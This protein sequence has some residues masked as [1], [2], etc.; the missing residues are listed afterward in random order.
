V[1]TPQASIPWSS[2]FTLLATGGNGTG[3]YTFSISGPVG[4]CS[5]AGNALSASG[6]GSCTI[7]AVRNADGNYLVSV[8]SAPATFTF[9]AKAQT[10]ITLTSTSGTY[11]V[12]LTMTFTGG[13]GGGALTYGVT[14]GTATGCS[15]TSGVLSS[16]SAGT[17]VVTVN[18]ASDTNYLA[19]SSAPTTV[20]LT[21]SGTHASTTTLVSS[22]SWVL[23]GSESKLTFTV[24]VSGKVSNTLPTGA[25]T[26]KVGST[27]ICVTTAFVRHNAHEISATCTLT[28]FQLPVGSYQM[29]AFYSGDTYY[30]PS[31]F[32]PLS[33]S[34]YSAPVI[35]SANLLTTT[36]GIP[37]TF[38][39]TATG[40]PAPTFSLSGSVPAGVSINATTG[41]LSGTVGAGTYHFTIKASNAAGSFSQAFT[42][43]S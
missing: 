20:A 36:H 43:H 25:V 27:V 26:F 5:L 28:N 12:G 4:D 39:V 6:A 31:Q 19:A 21:A 11:G 41:V 3:S 17:C 37:F 9:T 42:L 33:F 22:S 13:S 10:P 16:T 35:T 2:G 32:S 24:D 1:V 14:N 7:T 30:V 38:H 18:K 29:T 34:V 23:Y 8:A 40:S 15:I